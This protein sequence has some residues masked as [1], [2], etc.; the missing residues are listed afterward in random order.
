M[1]IGAQAVAHNGNTTVYTNT[2]TE[3]DEVTIQTGNVSGFDTFMVMSG[4]GAV[5]VYPSL[6]GTNYATSALSLQD[7]GATTTDPVVVT[8]AGRIYGFRGKYQKVRI[9]Q[10]GATD[11]AATL[12]CGRMG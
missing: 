6:D 2:S 9:V 11:V 12:V 5:D 8:A 3:D 10:N 7:M 1:T 4:T